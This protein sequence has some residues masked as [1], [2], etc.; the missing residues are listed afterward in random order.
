VIKQSASNKW[1]AYLQV[2]QDHPI[3]LAPVDKTKHLGLDMGISNFVYDSAGNH[4]EHPHNFDRLGEKLAREQRKLSRKHRGSKNR[5]KQR[6]RV[7]RVHERITNRRN[8]FLHKLSRDY[9]NNYDLIGRENLQVQNLMQGISNARNMADASWGRFFNMLG[10]K[11][12]TAC[13]LVIEVPSPHS[14]IECAKC[15]KMVP[16]TLAMRIHHCPY[17]GLRVDRDY[18]ASAVVD[19]RAVRKVGWEASEFTPVEIEPLLV[20]DNEQALSTKQE[21]L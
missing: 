21:L 5:I 16:K 18:N 14:S 9:V 2:E 13:T 15:H 8:N 12:E 10:Y 6:V 7:A 17:C 1:F 11:A 20:S 4:K 19:Y 3:N